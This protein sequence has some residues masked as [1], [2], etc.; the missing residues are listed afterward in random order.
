MLRERENI[1]RNNK[2]R[3]MGGWGDTEKTNGRWEGETGRHN[4]MTGWRKG[5][6]R[7]HGEEQM[8]R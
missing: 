4:E 2:D 6:T 7:G 5:K 8:G 1:R 3:E